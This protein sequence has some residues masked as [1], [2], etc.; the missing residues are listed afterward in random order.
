MVFTWSISRKQAVIC[1]KKN[2]EEEGAKRLELLLPRVFRPF[3]FDVVRDAIDISPNLKAVVCMDKSAPGWV[4]W[5]PYF[6][7]RYQAELNRLK[8]GPF[9]ANFFFWA[10]WTRFFPGLKA[11]EFW[12]AK[13][14]FGG[15]FPP[16]FH[17]FGFEGTW[18]LKQ[19]VKGSLN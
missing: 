10:W 13:G 4:L 6:N 2:R 18:V 17:G 3:P 14:L 11:Q 1:S 19:G 8:L 5:V 15:F 12:G 9:L 16:D 7:G